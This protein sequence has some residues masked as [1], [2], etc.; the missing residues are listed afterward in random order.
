LVPAVVSAL[1]AAA[2]GSPLPRAR[3]FLLP[4]DST[5]DVFLILFS[6]PCFCCCCCPITTSSLPSLLHSQAT[7]NNDANNNMAAGTTSN[8][9]D[10]IRIL[11]MLS[12]NCYYF[13]SLF[14]EQ[15]AA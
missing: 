12:A 14:F 7:K 15:L 1:A 9:D 4:I 10:D 5:A 3:N 6:I 8:D 13:D 2:D 11:M